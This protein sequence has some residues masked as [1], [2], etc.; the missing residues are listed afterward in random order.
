MEL[1]LTQYVGLGFKARTNEDSRRDR[2]THSDISEGVLLRNR[3]GWVVGGGGVEGYV[4]TP[5]WP[6]YIPG[7]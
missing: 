2:N 7:P 6:P 3:R 1:S 4:Q 5:K